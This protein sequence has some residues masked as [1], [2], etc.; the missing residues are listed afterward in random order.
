MLYRNHLL[1]E[2]QS[3]EFAR[4]IWSRR[5]VS[6]GLPADSPIYAFSYIDLPEPEPGLA[7]SVLRSYILNNDFPRAVS[8]DRKSIAIRALPENLI[9]VLQASAYRCEPNGDF[10][11]GIDWRHD[12]ALLILDKAVRW[13]DEE[14]AHVAGRKHFLE[15]PSLMSS[16]P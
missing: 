10:S 1:D 15:I 13:W 8:S 2:S 4:V 12:E 5:D 9:T 16:P 3:Q 14:K 7:Q 6:S 11:H